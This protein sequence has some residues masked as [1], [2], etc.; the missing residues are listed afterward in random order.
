[1]EQGM[2]SRG[3]EKE[4]IS[5]K[6]QKGNRFLRMFNLNQRM[7]LLILITAVPLTC[8]VLGIAALIHSYSSSYA[9]IMSNL[10]IANEYNMKFKEDMEYS[11][12]RVMI[13][14]LEPDQF[15]EGDIVEGKTQ[16]ATIVKNPYNMINSAREDFSSINREKGSDRDIKIKGLLS[17][18]DS[19]ETAVGKMMNASESRVVYDERQAIWENDIQGL[20]SMIQDYI[21]Q[22]IYYETLRMEELQKQMETST[23]RL[24]MFYLVLLAAVLTLGFM[25][26][27]MTARSVTGP[28]KDLTETARRLG[29]GDLK[30]RA[31][32]SDMEEINVLARTFNI[33]SDQI[34]GLMDKTKK[35]QENLRVMELKLRQEQINPHFLYNTL[36]SIVWMA[37]GGN[38]RQVV[39]MTSD[40]SE[41]FRT[42]LSE[43]QD[44]VTIAE[45]ENHIRSYLKIQKIR[46]DDVLDYRIEIE[47]RIRSRVVLKMILQPIVENALYHG[48][49]NKR[50][51]GTI[52]IRGYEDKNGVV[53]EVEDDGTGMDQETLQH[54]REK[55]KSR[56]E[57]K[58]LAVKAG[59]GFGLSNV[60][61]RISMYYGEKSGL[62]IESEKGV[63]TCVKVYL[64]HI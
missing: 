50:G 12:Y 10:R 25:I 31:R 22:Y 8:M 18:L 47:D 54:L 4:K 55:V 45:E 35:E 37:E 34:A 64:G 43:G 26:A 11:M 53:F 58:T 15:R 5:P 57:K 62:M 52:V 48:I 61:Q 41:F 27:A 40:L 20:C 56:H 42:V 29:A 14:L 59:G 24:L 7:G 32:M 21:N 30:A 16:Y 28:V 63:G 60:A 33:M 19:L 51:G 6:A 39:E 49:K 13:G 38:N 23:A 36:D 17:C 2:E 1:M 3:E 46:Y 44:F 9:A